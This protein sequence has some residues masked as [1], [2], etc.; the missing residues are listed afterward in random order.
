MEDTCILY[1]IIIL[2]KSP[3]QSRYICE[4]FLFC[5]AR[6]DLLLKK[7]RT[8]TNSYTKFEHVTE[9]CMFVLSPMTYIPN[10]G[11]WKIG[12]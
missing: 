6:Y 9:K 5:T 1:V 4:E 3:Y 10:A 8:L 7:L 2:L 12:W 11:T